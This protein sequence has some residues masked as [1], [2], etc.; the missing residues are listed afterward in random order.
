MLESERVLVIGMVTRWG[1]ESESTLGQTTEQRM[2]LEKAFESESTLG[3][4]T[5]QS[6]ELE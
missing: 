6:L 3:H 5:E 1:S 2:E 4:T